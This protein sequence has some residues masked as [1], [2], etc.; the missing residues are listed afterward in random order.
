MR[1]HSYVTDVSTIRSQLFIQLTHTW[2]KAQN[3]HSKYVEYHIT[4]A[5]GNR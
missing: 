3:L 1:N 5:K 4:S 2:N